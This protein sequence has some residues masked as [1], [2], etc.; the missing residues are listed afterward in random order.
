MANS[1][2]FWEKWV[3]KSVRVVHGAFEGARGVA[4]GTM[5]EN[6][7]VALPG[8]PGSVLW[9]RANDLVIEEPVL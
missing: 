5:K 7:Q 4:Q 8:E 3:G 2:E 6:V 9:F 1:E